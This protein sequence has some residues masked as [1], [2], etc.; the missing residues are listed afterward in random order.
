M[1]GTDRHSDSAV[2]LYRE[3]QDKPWAYHFY[4]AVRRIDCAHPDRPRTGHAARPEVEP[5]R[6]GQEAS[7]AFAPSGLASFLPGED[8][9][10][11]RME[12]LFFGLLGPNGPLPLHLTEYARDRLRNS[13]DPTLTRFLDVFH[14]RMLALFYRAWACAQ[15]TVEFDRPDADRFAA[16]VGSMFG[17]GMPSLRGRDG[18]QDLAKL[19]YAGRFAVQTRN[20]E[21]LEAI[22]SG[23]FR[24][25]VRIIQFIGQWLE[26]PEQSHCRLGESPET[27]ALGVTA[28]LGAYVWETQHKFRIVFGP[29]DQAHYERLLPQGDSLPRLV[30]LV[31]N[32]I[33]DQLNW[34]VEMILRKEEV[35][36]LELGRQGRLGWTTWLVS[37]PP[38]QDARDLRLHPLDYA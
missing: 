5:V 6:F 13:G 17:I 29:L 19:H 1:A 9:R 11:A 23:F 38:D 34:D 14:H 31:R 15:P 20:A 2:A 28:I 25:P 3:L 21:G 36:A 37:K 27:G 7:L 16:Y 22:L 4:E 30:A 10:A 26:L 24:L 33:G 35:P 32:Y 8:G 18:V 12:V